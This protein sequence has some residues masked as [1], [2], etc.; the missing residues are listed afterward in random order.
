[1]GNLMPFLRRII[2]FFFSGWQR[3]GRIFRT[4][5]HLFKFP[6]CQLWGSLEQRPPIT[7]HF[8]H[9]TSSSELGTLDNNTTK[10]YYSLTFTYTGSILISWLRSKLLLSVM[11]TFVVAAAR[12]DSNKIISS[13][14]ACASCETS[15]PKLLDFLNRWQSLILYVL[16]LLVPKFRTWKKSK[17]Y[18][19]KYWQILWYKETTLLTSFHLNSCHI[20]QRTVLLNSFHLNGH[21]LG[22]HPQ[23]QKL[24]PPCSA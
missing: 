10:M 2:T 3:L 24:E 6:C 8:K 7:E 4:A 1:M 9:F 5:S 11:L 12:W 16:S 22:F 15:Q 23:T 13:F 21:T 19:A 17:L 18:S 20:H 14:S